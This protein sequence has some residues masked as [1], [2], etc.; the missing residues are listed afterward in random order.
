MTTEK[1]EAE[2]ESRRARCA[3]DSRTNSDLVV[4]IGRV[5]VCGADLLFISFSTCARPLA[6]SSVLTVGLA[7][8]IQQHRRHPL[9]C[10]HV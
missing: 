1:D 9:S 2:Y 5:E 7:P 4:I 10:D 8:H 3:R 6:I